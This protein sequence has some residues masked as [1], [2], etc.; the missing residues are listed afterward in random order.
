[1]RYGL[2]LGVLV[3]SVPAWAGK[4][5]MEDLPRQIDSQRSGAGD[6]ERFDERRSVTDEIGLR[7]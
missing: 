7:A 4:R 1:M 6:L 2:L 5:E 3:L